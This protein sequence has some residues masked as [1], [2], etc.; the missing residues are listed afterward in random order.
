MRYV[1]LLLLVCLGFS[2]N[3]QAKSPDE[4]PATTIG[5]PL[6]APDIHIQVQGLPSG[7]AYLVG[8]YAEQRFRA[9]S[10]AVDTKGQFTFQRAEPYQPGFYFV[11]MPDNTALQVLIDADQTFSLKTQAGDLIGAMQAEGS[12]DNEL[13][14]R[15]L[16]FEQEIQ[17]KF[18]SVSERM[19]A[20]GEGSPIYAQLKAQQ[21][22]LIA[23][24]K[25]H[26]K[27]FTDN[28]PD[29]FF[30]KFKIAGQ[31]PDVKDVRNPDGSVNTQLQV[32]YYRTEF[33]GNVDFSDER[34]LYTPV[35]YN[36]L[37]RYIT[38]LTVQN[39]DSIIASTGQLMQK[40]TGHDEYFKFFANWIT[41]NYDP[42]KTSLMDPQAIFVYMIQ[43]YF[44]YERA[45]WSD[46][47]QIFG[48]QQR[49]HEMAASLVGK[50]G[51]NV[52][53]KDPSGQLRS[54]YDLKAP[55]V[56]VYMYNPT[57]EHCMEQTPKLIQLYYEW[58]NKGLDV[59]GIA[60]DTDDAEWKDYIAKT[61]MPWTNVFDPTNKAIYTK[62]YV[63]ITPEIYVLG[64][65]RTIIA[66]NLKVNQ[67]PEVIERDKAKRH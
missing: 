17:P 56:I 14:Y 29:A 32:Y 28:Y 18:Q 46:S 54:I 39:P 6:E 37:N 7:T 20:A 55:Y 59:Y 4:T 12:L 1:I 57:C 15:N 34:L 58:R 63:D 41:L 64:P 3:S 19:K 22:Q 10:A 51:P 9:D 21:E 60:V 31:N 33:W 25:A 35:I 52:T 66:K 26:I 67:I 23:Q 38:E 36:K 5:A 40:A 62:Y 61:G 11:Y 47:V 16:K 44:T 65:D 48:L 24:R 13:L 30:T 8:H 2:C 43:N 27:E 42:E 53:A 45:F 50:K 49:A